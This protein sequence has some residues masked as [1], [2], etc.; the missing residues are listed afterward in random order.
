MLIA[1]LSGALLFC[2]FLALMFAQERPYFRQRI[3]EAEAGR[4]Q[5]EQ[6]ALSAL[7]EVEELRA[8]MPRVTRCRWRANDMARAAKKAHLN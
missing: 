2:A 6:D 3:A 4:Y 5:A 7:C 1:I 8:A